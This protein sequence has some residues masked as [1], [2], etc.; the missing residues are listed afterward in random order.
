VTRERWD[1]IALWLLR[2]AA[3]LLCAYIL[4]LLFG[5]LHSDTLVYIA[6]PMFVASLAI[7]T[8]DDWNPR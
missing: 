1:L 6:A 2:W 4:V 7:H 5:H 3:G 8:Y